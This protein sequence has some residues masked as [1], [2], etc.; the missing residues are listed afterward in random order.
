MSG[1]GAAQGAIAVSLL[2]PDAEDLD[3][4]DAV[5]AASF[6]NAPFSARE[7]LAKPWTRC[8]VA[9]EEG[10]ARA[11]LLAWHVADELHVLNIA[12]APEARRR[13]IAAALMRASLEYAREHHVRILL[14][15]VR[16]SNL[17]AIRLYRSLGFTTLSVR[18]GYYGDNG[19]DAVEMILVMDPVTGAIQPGKDEV[20]LDA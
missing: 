5:A 7:E 13:G 15:E 8:W 3:G 6:D 18:K 1:G 16:R 4:I 12:T 10:D 17:P 9:R 2:A 19:E 20:R 14:L 11:F